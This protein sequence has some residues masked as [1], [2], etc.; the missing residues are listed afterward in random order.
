MQ[1][2]EVLIFP[3]TA[4]PLLPL[5]PVGR[6]RQ[7]VRLMLVMPDRPKALPRLHVVAEG[8][9]GMRHVADVAARVLRLPPLLGV[10][11]DL[12]ELAANYGQLLVVA[13][14]TGVRHLCKSRPTTELKY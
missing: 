10:V 9:D 1:T 6:L 8:H 2:L 7:R 12:E 11:D 13:G 3:T 5:K 14:R 4:T